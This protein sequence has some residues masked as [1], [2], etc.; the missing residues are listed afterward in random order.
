[1]RSVVA[2]RLAAF[3]AVVLWGVSF[4]ATKAALR[5]VSPVTLIFA[6]FALGI[7]V[8]FLILKLRRESLVPPRDAWLMLAVMGFVGIFVH[9]MLQVHGLTLTTAVRT[10]WLI[11]LI[12]IWSALLAAMFLG[13]S[14]G[15]RKV[16]G[17]FLGTVGAVLV[18]TRGELSSRVLALPATRGDLLILAS[19]VNWAIYTIL[20]RETLKRLGSSRATAAAMFVGWAMLIPFFVNTAGWQEYRYLSST[21]VIAIV[22]LG[23]GCSGL[24]YLF[25]YAALERIEASQVAAFLYLEPLV[26]LMAAVA[27]LGESVA[28][29]TILGGVLVLAGVLTVQAEKSRDTPNTNTALGPAAPA[30]SGAEAQ[31]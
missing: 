9:Q 10:G 19:T 21:S 5:E 6:R 8:L 12:P 14:F 4:V 29:S 13:E 30:Q 28:V 3:G 20:G 26:T 22:F 24:G 7:A 1:M 11:G 16:F 17:L 23:V 2:A 18:I 31:R 15:P 25:W 27:L